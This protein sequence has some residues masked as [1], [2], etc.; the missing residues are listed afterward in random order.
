MCACGVELL[1]ESRHESRHDLADPGLCSEHCLRGK[2]LRRVLR[3][4]AYAASGFSGAHQ[5]TYA[6]PCSASSGRELLLIAGAL[7]WK[8]FLLRCL[9]KVV[10]GLDEGRQ[11]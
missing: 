5:T 7:T 8:A 1:H 3:T 6:G 4:P 2:P 10:A 9:A 11:G